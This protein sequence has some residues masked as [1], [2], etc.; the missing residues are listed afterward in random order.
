MLDAKLKM[1]LTIRFI[2]LAICAF[3][4]APKPARAQNGFEIANAQFQV[5]FHAKSGGVILLR[6]PNDSALNYVLSPADHPKLDVN[7]S[8]WLGDIVLR[9]RIGGEGPWRLATSGLSEDDREIA[10]SK[11]GSGLHIRYSGASVHPQGING[12]ALHESWQFGRNTLLWTI[13]LA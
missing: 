4:A 1:R 8:R 10:P 6:N 12:I 3:A 2:A 13:R 7:D 5:G 9:Y 11:D